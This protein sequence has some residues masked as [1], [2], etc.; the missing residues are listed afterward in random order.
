MVPKYLQPD[1]YVELESAACAPIRAYDS[2][3][4]VDLITKKDIRLIKGLRTLIGTGVKVEIPIGFVGLLFPRSSLSNNY[5]Y[6]T[7]SVG[8]IDSSYRGEIK[9]SLLY[10]GDLEYLDMSAGVRVVQ[11]V[12]VP[13]VLPTFIS[14]HELSST[15]RGTSGFGSTGK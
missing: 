10:D 12:I 11:L 4:G 7:N 13:I 8:V 6:M 9:A 5:I 15:N 3:A 14:V 1:I 2:D